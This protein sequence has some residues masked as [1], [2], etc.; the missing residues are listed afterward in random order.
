[1]WKSIPIVPISGTAAVT[2]VTKTTE[3]TRSLPNNRGLPFT[4]HSSLRHGASTML[5][6]AL[7]AKRTQPE[8]VIDHQQEII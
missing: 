3:I 2:R 4:L 6:A 8:V 7:R 1:M 5:V